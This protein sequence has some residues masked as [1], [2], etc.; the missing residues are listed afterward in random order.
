MINR[1][2]LSGRWPVFEGIFDAVGLHI[3]HTGENLRIEDVRSELRYDA[4]IVRLV[5][6][7][8]VHNVAEKYQLVPNIKAS[9]IGP[10]G[11]EIQS[12]QIDAPAAKLDPGVDGSVRNDYQGPGQNRCERQSGIHRV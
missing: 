11:S 3:N 6:E 8:K 9:A 12:W 4:G 1:E 7:G 10:D 5:V 2:T